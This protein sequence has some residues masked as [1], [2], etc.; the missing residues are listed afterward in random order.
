MVSETT[1]MVLAEGHKHTMAVGVAGDD[2][3]GRSRQRLEDY[4]RLAAWR[5]AQCGGRASRPPHCYFTG[6]RSAA[7]RWLLE[8]RVWV[9]VTEEGV[10]P[11]RGVLQLLRGGVW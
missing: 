4:P 3:A 5:N 10:T 6:L 7:G 1:P 9:E 2:L 8:P 11:G